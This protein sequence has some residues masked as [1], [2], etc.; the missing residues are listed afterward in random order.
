MHASKLKL[1]AAKL[2]LKHV[3][4]LFSIEDMRGFEMFGLITNVFS[5]SEGILYEVLS[6]GAIWEIDLSEYNPR[7]YD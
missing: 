3:G 5:D 7:F 1:K 2:K 4:K 6:G